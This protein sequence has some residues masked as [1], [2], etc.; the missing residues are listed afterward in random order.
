MDLLPQ[1]PNKQPANIHTHTNCMRI[2]KIH[3]KDHKKE[4]PNSKQSKKTIAKEMALHLSKE[5]LYIHIV[6]KYFQFHLEEKM[7]AEKEFGMFF[8]EGLRILLYLNHMFSSTFS[9]KRLKIRLCI[10]ESVVM[11]IN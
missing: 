3:K 11:T 7:S 9:I 2:A 6:W 1:Y 8:G 4:I 10:G 5:F